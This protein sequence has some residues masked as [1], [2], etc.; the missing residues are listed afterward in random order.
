MTGPLAAKTL[1]ANTCT[2]Q[3]HL[4]ADGNGT[5]MAALNATFVNA[6]AFVRLEHKRLFPGP[7]FPGST[8][9]RIDFGSAAVGDTRQLSCLP[10]YHDLKSR[11]PDA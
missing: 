9:L 10:G 5:R 11:R 2:L 8:E 6:A 7:Q 1:G 3:S 4:R